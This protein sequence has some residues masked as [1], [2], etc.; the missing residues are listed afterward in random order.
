M[1]N[2][3]YW[4]A[5]ALL[6]TAFALAACG[7]SGSATGSGDVT[8]PPPT[9]ATTSGAANGASGTDPQGGDVVTE[10][11]NGSNNL[12]GPGDASGG[13]AG[14]DAGNATDVGSGSDGA[15]GSGGSDQAGGSQAPN[16]PNGAVTQG[17]ATGNS[18]SGTGDT[19]SSQGTAG[20]TDNQ[21]AGTGGTA[22]GSPQNS[23]TV[24]GTQGSVGTASAVTGTNGTQAAAAQSSTAGAA[25][26]A[27]AAPGAAGGYT[28]I[29]DAACTEVQNQLTQALGIDVSRSTAPAA[30]QDLN[31]GTGQSCQ[32]T[33][34]ATGAQFP[35]MVDAGQRIAG[36]LTSS[37][38]TLDPQYAADS[39]TG[40]M[41]GLRRNNQL[42]VYN[43]Q[44]APAAGIIC[45][46][47]Q[48]IAICAESLK[49]EQMVYTITVDLAQQ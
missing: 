14:N 19:G 29:D 21:G 28:P 13:N 16:Q 36:A 45:P 23:G 35:N 41:H 27:Q 46:A 2:K 17:D 3:N 24:T 32:L 42:A 44:W 38:W 12:G 1:N 6:L 31:G 22:A 11:A 33:I 15:Q 7:S 37:G 40:T 18:A 4:L 34:A 47:D 9:T 43:V 39:P 8:N 20:D 10:G 25:A 49:P 5:L 30:F 26:G 48:P